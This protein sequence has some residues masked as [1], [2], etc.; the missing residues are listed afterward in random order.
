MG[1]YS[2]AGEEL[3]PFGDDVSKPDGSDHNLTF[4]L[5]WSSPAVD[6]VQSAPVNT[7]IRLFSNPESAF[8]DGRLVATVNS[9]GRSKL[10]LTRRGIG[11][12]LHFCY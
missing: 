5:E 8:T 10:I 2:E 12:S 3:L 7:Q 9:T 4:K 11:L 6:G 1:I